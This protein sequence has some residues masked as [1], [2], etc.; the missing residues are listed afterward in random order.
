V[1]R[2]QGVGAPAG[3]NNTVIKYRC[4]DY[5]FIFY[6]LYLFNNKYIL[7]NL[8]NKNKNYIKIKII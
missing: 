8:I 4:D 6:F 3:V 2:N 7:I 1:L 5:T